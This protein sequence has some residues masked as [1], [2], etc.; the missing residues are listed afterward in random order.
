MSAARRLLAVML[1]LTL[2]LGLAEG[3][4][5]L[6]YDAPPSLAALEK[7]KPG[8]AARDAASVGCREWKAVPSAMVPGVRR[9]GKQSL[10][11]G[12]DSVAAGWGV[13]TESSFAAQVQ[14]AL[15]RRHGSVDLVLDA[16]AGASLCDEVA[17]LRGALASGA[18]AP[19]WALIGVFADDLVRHGAMYVGGELVA[20]PSA[21]QPPELGVALRSSWLLNLAWFARVSRDPGQLDGALPASLREL[22]VRALA[23][24]DAAMLDSGVKRAWLLIPGVNQA[25][26]PARSSGRAAG[27]ARPELASCRS[28]NA[29][30][31]ALREVFAD[32][33]VPLVDLD[34]IYGDGAAYRLP[35]EA[36]LQPP[37]TVAVHP[38][39][40]GHALIAARALA[41]LGE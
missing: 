33:G 29:G 14:G 21:V 13:P 31:L 36:H 28:L 16:Q 15:T 17:R 11:V 2:G 20:F 1:S 12:G 3:A 37:D 41:A 26:C 35:G 40:A 10:Y 32:A 25:G 8:A 4:L 19:R 30:R 24:A 22:V 39:A 6:R 27:P 38:N 23:D 9:D 7:V 5:R 34:G 18:P